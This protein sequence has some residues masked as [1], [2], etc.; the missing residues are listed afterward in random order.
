MTLKRTVEKLPYAGRRF[1]GLREYP[2]GMFLKGDDTVRILVDSDACPVKDLI[3]QAAKKRDIPVLWIVSTAHS[4]DF[5]QPSQVVTVDSGPEAVDL[6]LVNRVRAGD[7][8]VTQDYGLAAL[9]LQKKAKAISCRGREYRGEDMD[10]LL[11]ERYIG[12]KI[13]RAGGRT[14]GPAPMTEADRTLFDTVLQNML[15]RMLSGN[16]IPCRKN[17]EN[18]D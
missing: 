5:P 15:D 18:D 17:I 9:C 14:R 7:L 11:T 4:T 16:E 10:R 12:A 6:A 13:R 2:L 8:V 3:W 1:I